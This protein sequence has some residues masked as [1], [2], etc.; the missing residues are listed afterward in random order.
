MPIRE[1]STEYLPK[2][3]T[4]RVGNKGRA[5][6]GAQSPP[7]DPSWEEELALN[8]PSYFLFVGVD[9]GPPES[10]RNGNVEDPE[11]TFFG[12]VIRYV[13]EEPYYYMLS[14]G[15]GRFL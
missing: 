7:S 11:N 6:L 4:M 2:D 14:E 9:C 3:L 10:I 1:Q 13:C 15:N 12:S 5:W 8:V